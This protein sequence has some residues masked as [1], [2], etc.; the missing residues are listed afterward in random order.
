MGYLTGGSS[1]SLTNSLIKAQQQAAIRRNARMQNQAD[2]DPFSTEDPQAAQYAQQA[3]ASQGGMLGGGMMSPGMQMSEN[4]ANPDQGMGLA[5]N[6]G[7]FLAQGLNPATAPK[8]EPNDFQNPDGSHDWAHITSALIADISRKHPDWSPKHQ[9]AEVQK[10]LFKSGDPGAMEQ[11]GKMSKWGEHLSDK[12][13][14]KFLTPEEI[15][16]YPQFKDLPKGT[17]IQKKTDG[18]MSIFDKG[19]AW[20]ISVLPVSSTEEQTFKVS[21]RP[22][23]ETGEF[24]KV[25]IG[26]TRPIAST[27]NT[28][29]NNLGPNDPSIDGYPAKIIEEAKASHGAMTIA[30]DSLGE[31]ARKVIAQFDKNGPALT[32]IP[33][34]ALQFASNISGTLVSAQRI[35]KARGETDAFNDLLS[36]SDKYSDFFTQ[37][38]IKTEVAKANLLAMAYEIAQVRKQTK[39]SEGRIAEKDIQNALQTLGA[40]SSNPEVMKA[41]MTDTVSGVFSDVRRHYE[42]GPL[43]HLMG[44]KGA[45]YN[46][47]AMAATGKLYARYP[48]FAPKDTKGTPDVAPEAA[49]PAV[50]PWPSPAQV[51]KYAKDHFGGDEAQAAD[52]LSAHGYKRPK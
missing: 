38:G 26:H 44:P 17:V 43:S 52:Y 19:D 3:D 4:L 49:T 24:D 5:K 36:N 8:Q 28:N 34:A 45:E 48:E 22:D 46:N 15:A 2:S 1:M 51:S 13:D 18:E 35:A 11:V 32:G 16:Q 37:Y 39:E 14:A 42:Y 7:L 30:A 31:H 20:D 12:E 29:V 9:I 23:P 25:P 33:G 41:V 10:A 47:E 50:R 6:A 40:G 21:K 27:V